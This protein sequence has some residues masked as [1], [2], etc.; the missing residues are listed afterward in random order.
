MSEQSNKSAAERQKQGQVMKHTSKQF[1]RAMRAYEEVKME[2]SGADEYEVLRGVGA[3]FAQTDVGNADRLMVKYGSRM[4]YTAAAGW[5]VYDGKRWDIA[6]GETRA[7]GIA[8]EVARAI[9]YEC[10]EFDDEK[11]VAR[12][13]AWAE[14]SGRASALRGMLDAAAPSLSV[15]IAAFDARPHLWNASN[16]TVDLRTGVMRPHHPDDMLVRMSPVPYHPGAE[17][18]TWLRFLDDVFMGDTEMIGFMQRKVGYSM[19]GHQDEQKAFVYTGDESNADA[20]GSNG[21]SLF[22]A[23]EGEIFGEYATGVD[24]SLIVEERNKG[25]INNDVA[26]LA[27]ARLGLGSEFKKNDVLSDRELKRLTGDDKISARFL[28]RE[29]FNF[30]SQCTLSYSSNYMPLITGQDDGIWRRIVMIP[31]KAK[32]LDQRD[33]DRLVKEGK[34]PAG[35]KLKDPRMKAKLLEELPGILAWAVAGA[36]AYHRDGLGVPERLYVARDSKKAE[37]DPFADFMDL[38]LE[39]GQEHSITSADLNRAYVNFC[40][41]NRVK[42]M[43]DTAL[44]LRVKGRGVDKDAELTRIRRQTVRRGACLSDIGRLYASGVTNA[45]QAVSSAQVRAVS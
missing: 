24:R 43:T 6:G 33:W 29:Y 37:F 9:F 22:Q 28:R 38:C 18:P 23:I 42:P 4:A 11:A 40:E 2:R 1:R 20:N 39:F 17:A 27:G 10:K 8:G 21:K 34:V 13:I 16:G 30:V 14:K 25:A 32:F 19:F 36:V 12:R 15:D 3:K 31:F 26:A 7:M 5:A 45:M 41:V 44:G 35:G